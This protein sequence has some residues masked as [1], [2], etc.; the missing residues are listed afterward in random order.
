MSE[1]DNLPAGRQVWKQESIN[2][3][4]KQI[5]TLADVAYASDCKSEEQS[6]IL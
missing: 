2:T 3:H 4:F 6:S 1:F 5:G